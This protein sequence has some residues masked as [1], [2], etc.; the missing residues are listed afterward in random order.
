MVDVSQQYNTLMQCIDDDNA[1]L[2]ERNVHVPETETKQLPEPATGLFSSADQQL[3]SP[4]VNHDLT[5]ESDTQRIESP[6]VC[7]HYD[8]DLE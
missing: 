6:H 8:S 3:Q 7:D 2:I 4:A 5:T 1:D